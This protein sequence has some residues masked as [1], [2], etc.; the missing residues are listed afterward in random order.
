[1][2]PRTLHERLED[3]IG[4]DVRLFYGLLVPA[5]IVVLL[6]VV[7]ALSPAWWLL[8]PLV[9]VLIGAIGVV[10]VGINQMLDED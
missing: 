7:L 2:E 6:V 10:M 1:M 3:R 4:V 9:I 8:V 5:A